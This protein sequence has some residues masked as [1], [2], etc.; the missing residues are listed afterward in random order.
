[1]LPVQATSAAGAGGA[2]LAAGAASEVGYCA[3]VAAVAGLCSAFVFSWI[4][5]AKCG[6]LSRTSWHCA[7]AGAAAHQRAHLDLGA[8]EG[9]GSGGGGGAAAGGRPV[10]GFTPRAV[11]QHRDEAPKSNADFRKMMLGGGK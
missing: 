7:A 6:Q 4:Q 11:A 10:T 1:M 8:G 3:P 2:A 9:G 5:A